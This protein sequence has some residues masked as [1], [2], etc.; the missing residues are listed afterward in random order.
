MRRSPVMSEDQE[1]IVADR[2]SA[3]MRRLEVGAFRAPLLELPRSR[4]R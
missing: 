3:A 1:A 2:E 4:P